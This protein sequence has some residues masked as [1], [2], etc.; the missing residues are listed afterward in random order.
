MYDGD[1]LRRVLGG[2]TS[3]RVGASARDGGEKKQ[4]VDLWP[5]GFRMEP[6]WQRSAH[7]GHTRALVLPGNGD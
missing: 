4:I 3:S 6:D 7:V 1:R 2:V 5:S